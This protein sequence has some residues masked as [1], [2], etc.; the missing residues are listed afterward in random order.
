MD[1]HQKASRRAKRH[2]LSVLRKLSKKAKKHI[3]DRSNL[4]NVADDEPLVFEQR[5]VL[6]AEG[7]LPVETLVAT[8]NLFKNQQEIADA[9]RAIFKSCIRPTEDPFDVKNIVHRC[10]IRALFEE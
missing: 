8:H 10:G 2:N 7:Q 6:R 3:S 1:A 9:M 4:K 5:A